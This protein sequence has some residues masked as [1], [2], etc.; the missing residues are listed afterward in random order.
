MP[1]AAREKSESG[2][3]HAMVRGVN[4]QSIFEE[5]AD[6]RKF[7]EVVSLCKLIGRFELYA[8]CLMGNHAHMLIKPDEREQLD[9]VFRRIGARYVGWFNRKYSRVGHL[10]QDRYASEPVDTD[11]YFASCVRYILRNPVEAG[12]CATPFDYD[13][14]SAREYAGQAVGPTDTA[15]A[16]D[17]IGRDRFAGFVS[18]PNDRKHL[19]VADV[20]RM[21]DADLREVM[22]RATGCSDASAFQRLGEPDRD[23]GLRAL[24]SAGGSIRQVSRVTGVNVGVVRR[25][26]AS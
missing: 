9:I 11:E 3:Y 20:F 1:R 25:I 15:R 21:T 12:M 6:C 5:P 26:I 18:A 17:L 24:R 22:G 16:L 2:V 13:F 8:Y 19:D 23:E 14:S 4:R 10:F 7:L